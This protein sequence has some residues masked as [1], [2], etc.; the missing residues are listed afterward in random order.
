MYKILPTHFIPIGSN[1]DTLQA[2]NVHYRYILLS[3]RLIWLILQRLVCR[4]DDKSHVSDVQATCLMSFLFCSQRTTYSQLSAATE[5][6]H[7]SRVTGPSCCLL[8]SWHWN[9]HFTESHLQAE[10]KSIG[11]AAVWRGG[12]LRTVHLP[13]VERWEDYSPQSLLDVTQKA[14]VW[15]FCASQT[16]VLLVF[17][18]HRLLPEG[19]AAFTFLLC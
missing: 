7:S 19:F 13:P 9:T 4:I 5:V 3:H 1:E 16:V 2:H 14:S 15:C 11:A 6:E 18:K 10:P 17:K 12:E 8:S